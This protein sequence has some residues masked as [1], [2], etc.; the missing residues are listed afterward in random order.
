MAIARVM[1]FRDGFRCAFCETQWTGDQNALC[2]ANPDR[3]VHEWVPNDRQWLHVLESSVIPASCW[4]AGP[5]LPEMH[6]R[7][8]GQST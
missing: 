5:E 4:D 8:T 6:L 1:L 3:Q 7:L 2:W